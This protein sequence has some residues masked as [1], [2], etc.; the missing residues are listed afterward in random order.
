[1]HEQARAVPIAPVAFGP[2]C[3]PA[4]PL[5]KGLRGEFLAPVLIGHD[6]TSRAWDLWR[7]R[8]GI[9]LDGERRLSFPHTHLGIEAAAQGMGVALVERRLISRE[10]AAGTL[11]APFGF[12]PFEDPLAAIPSADAPP[13]PLGF[14]IDWLRETLSDA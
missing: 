14:F 2:V 3:A 6:F 5:S 1:A 9:T 8:A 4:Y 13:E 7:D 10:L 11:T 12:T